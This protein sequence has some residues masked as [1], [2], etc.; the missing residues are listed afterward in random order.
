M[1]DKDNEVNQL[2]DKYRELKAQLQKKME[3]NK[4]KKEQYASIT[5]LNSK[6]KKMICSN[7]M[8]H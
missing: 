2:R 3:V 4:D 8:Y 6:M 7:L 1:K 5:T